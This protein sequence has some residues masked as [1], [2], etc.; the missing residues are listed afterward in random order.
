MLIEET[1]I[2]DKLYALLKGFKAKVLDGN[3]QERY[4]AVMLL[5][6]G[7]DVRRNHVFMCSTHEF[8]A[9]G[10]KWEDDDSDSLRRKHLRVE[11]NNERFAFSG[12]QNAKD[13]F[14]A[15]THEFQ[16]NSLL[17]A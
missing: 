12:T 3:A 4:V 7:P 8:V 9:K 10:G 15:S 16:E 1:I 2:Y 5:V 6:M 14:L 13:A 11:K 17:R